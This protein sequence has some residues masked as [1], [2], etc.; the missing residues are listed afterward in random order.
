MGEKGRGGVAQGKSGHVGKGER[1]E[2]LRVR[3]G[4]GGKGRGRVRVGWGNREGYKDVVLRGK[5][6]SNQPKAI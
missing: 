4:M 1:V 5:M 2:W 3:V 6:Q